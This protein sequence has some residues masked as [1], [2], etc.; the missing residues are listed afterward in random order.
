MFGI[1]KAY[2]Y[3]A[4]TRKTQ[5]ERPTDK[6]AEGTIIMDLGTPEPDSDKEQDEVSFT[7]GEPVH[8]GYV[9]S[10][11]YV[12][13]HVLNAENVLVHDV[14]VLLCLKLSVLLSV[15]VRLISRGGPE[16]PLTAITHI[17][18]MKLLPF[19]LLGLVLLPVP[20]LIHP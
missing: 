20:P 7:P 6:D 9:R 18:Q 14:T 5:W 4:I 1:G 19:L 3:H 10:P 15:I 13:V 2:Y 17:P 11:G 8:V 16:P 12:H